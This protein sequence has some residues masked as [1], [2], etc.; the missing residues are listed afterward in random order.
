MNTLL[1]SR[2]VEL[3]YERVKYKLHVRDARDFFIENRMIFVL[4]GDSMWSKYFLR[5]YE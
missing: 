2:D 1:T 5:S 3:I 4:L